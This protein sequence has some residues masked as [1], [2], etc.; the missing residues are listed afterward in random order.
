LCS[1]GTVYALRLRRQGDKDRAGRQVD[2]NESETRAP[3]DR[4]LDATGRRCCPR[5][6][7]EN[8]FHQP[9]ATQEQSDEVGVIVDQRTDEPFTSSAAQRGRAW[10]RRWRSCHALRYARRRGRRR[11]TAGSCRARTGRRP[12]VPPRCAQAARGRRELRGAQESFVAALKCQ[13]GLCSSRFWGRHRGAFGAPP[14]LIAPVRVRAVA[15]A[16]RP[17]MSGRETLVR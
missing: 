16:N 17:P 11:S 6:E 15:A 12:R 5:R 13:Q 9:G 3:P 2:S 10:V 4:T 1:T 14:V 8:A 7:R